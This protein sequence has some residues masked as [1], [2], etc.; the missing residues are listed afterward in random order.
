M[1][2]ISDLMQVN[3]PGYRA[4]C[5]GGDMDEVYHPVFFDYCIKVCEVFTKYAHEHHNRMLVT[6]N[7]LFH[8]ID[9]LKSLDETDEPEDVFPLRERIR[10]ACYTFMT[11]CEDMASKFKQPSTIKEFYDNLG[12]LVLTVACEYSGGEH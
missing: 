1:I 7:S 6:E 3:H 12:K 9:A 8:I 11:H 5:I 10:S 4:F 2:P